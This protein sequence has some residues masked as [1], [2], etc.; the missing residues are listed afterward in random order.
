MFFILKEYGFE[1]LLGRKKIGECFWRTTHIFKRVKALVAER[2]SQEEH[3][4][5][6]QY[7]S[8]IDGSKD[9]IPHYVYTDHT[10][11]ANLAS[12]PYFT[13][14]DLYSRQWIDLERT[15]YHNA[16]LN[17]TRTSVVSRSIVEDY[18][19]PPDKVV[20]VYSGSNV[21]TGF[22]VNDEKYRAKTIVFV[23]LEWERKGGPELVEAFGRVLE[24]H[25]DARLVIVGC[26]PKV[27]LRNCDVVGQVPIEAL[28]DW[29][30]NA[31]VF[32][33][34]A[35]IEPSFPIVCVEAFA[36]RL[37][38]VAT[39]VEGM[40]DLVRDGETGF[41]V[42]AGDVEGLSKA[43]INL[44]SDPEKCRALG[45]NGRRL[46]LERYNWETVGA[47]MARNIRATVGAR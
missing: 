18:S 5:S 30:E 26:S 17:F 23:G 12:Y 19:C 32:C 36:H 41:L 14:K 20:C 16:R 4:F 29:Y 27:N 22:A 38:V 2:L 40:P 24:A 7:Q 37:P 28:D 8:L 13:E 9:G 11:L 31:S 35:R 10:H 43:L 47:E 3:M 21:G 6:F 42:K 45:E 39:D 44:L 1:I 34:P 46:V 25:P 33:L 15:I